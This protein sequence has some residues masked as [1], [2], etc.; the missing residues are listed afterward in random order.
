MSI[1]SFSAARAPTSRGVRGRRWRQ[2]GLTV[3]AVL[4]A[5]CCAYGAYAWSLGRARAVWLVNGL[6]RAYE[7][8]INGRAYHMEPHEAVQVKLPEG[9]LR[10]ASADASVPFPEL[11]CVLHTPLLSR[12]FAAKPTFVLNP[13]RAALLCEVDALF[14]RQAPKTFDEA[15]RYRLYVGELLYRFDGIDY[16][17]DDLPRTVAD[18]DAAGADAVHKKT[19]DVW[20]IGTRDQQFNLVRKELGRPAAAAFAKNLAVC[21]PE[22]QSLLMLLPSVMSPDEVIA[23]FRSRLDY[24]PVQVCWHKMYQQFVQRQ[25]PEYDVQA[26]YRARLAR[27]PADTSLMYLLAR[28]IDDRDESEKWLRESTHGAY[29]SGHGFFAM[30]YRLLAKGQF[31]RALLMADQA[32]ALLPDDPEVQLIQAEALAAA[33]R[34]DKLLLMA[35]QNQQTYPLDPLPAMDEIRVLAVKGD[36]KRAD[37]AAD[38]FAARLTRQGRAA[39]VGPFRVRA[40]AQ[41][42]YV[43]GDVARFASSLAQVRLSADELF[44]T[45]LALGR[46]DEAAAGLSRNP[47]AKAGEHLLLAVAAMD[48]EREDLATRH[49]NLAASGYAKGDAESRRLGRWLAGSTLPDPDD[50]CALVMLPD[51]KRLVLAA[52]GLRDAA[53]RDRYFRAAA[54][55][56]YDHAF[57]Y[58]TLKKV[59]DGPT[60][61]MK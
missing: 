23:F 15:G 57:P 46:L 48:A 20:T 60:L 13:D 4:A 56:N 50:V 7:A 33:G 32:A 52:M 45:N 55:L 58:W 43:A 6:D 54:A 61:A 14:A 21:N 5:S 1:V 29:P 35:R 27:E 3:L 18:A 28:T 59:L 37:L 30:A 10:V 44:R 24:R 31:E 16:P 2:V 25:H 12:P 17:F 41:F 11:T 9:E 39:G 47:L 38:A 8:T 53:H 22:S 19:V 26:E 40:R 42:D 36:A 34:Y 49:L 51:Q